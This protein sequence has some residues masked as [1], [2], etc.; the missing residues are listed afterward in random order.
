M[1][2]RLQNDFSFSF[3]RNFTFHFDNIYDN[4]KKY[5]NLYYHI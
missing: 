1:S 5:C 4:D 3:D 2:S